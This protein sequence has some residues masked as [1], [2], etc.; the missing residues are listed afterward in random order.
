MRLRWC[1]VIAIAACGR[2]GFDVEGARTTLRLDRVDPGE[3][4]D[5]FP[6][7]VV[8][9]DTRA[10]RDLLDPD[11]AN[12]RFLDARG[13]VLAH[14]IEQVGLSGGPPLIAW[15]RVPAIAGTTTTLTAVIG[16]L[17]APSAQSVW[18]ESFEAVYHL[19]QDATDATIN[20]H[21]GA[22]L[23]AGIATT[24]GQIGPCQVFS[25]AQAYIINDTATLDVPQLTL[26]GW[27]NP[28]VLEATGFRTLIVRAVPDSTGDDFYLGTQNEAEHSVVWLN[29]G[30]PIVLNVAA[31]AIPLGRWTHLA[32]VADGVQLTSYLDGA[33][34]GKISAPGPIQ[35]DAMPVV[36]GADQNMSPV[37]NGNFLDG[38]ADEIRIEH[39]VRSAAWLRYDDLAQRDQV[40][41]YGVVER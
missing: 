37:P 24:D 41:S 3:P 31:A 27:I 17:S 38:L 33:P 11:A 19:A 8:L 28:R 6:L 39:G 5:N 29:P 15:V 14:E 26:S 20:H 2:I 16:P 21:D 1:I 10:A 13:A 9:D 30:G 36:I 34:T 23:G 22:A 35:H 18:S 12:L 25:G 32:F 7:L 4:I 40:I